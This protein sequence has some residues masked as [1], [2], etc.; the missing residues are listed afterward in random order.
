MATLHSVHLP[1]GHHRRA[2]VRVGGGGAGGKPAV[3]G[4][5]GKLDLGVTTGPLARNW[6]Q[7]WGSS[8]LSTVDTFERQAGKHAAIVM[9]YADWQHSARSLASQLERGRTPREHTRDQLGALGRD[10][11]AV[12][13]ATALPLEQHYQR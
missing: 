9:W 13:P 2:F 6:W 5:A 4:T 7:S 3:G 8:D 10:Q 12:G 1:A 11:G